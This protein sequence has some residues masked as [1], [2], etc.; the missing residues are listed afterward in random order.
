MCFA[1]RL[2]L[3]AH[4]LNC[5]PGRAWRDG[6]L[7]GRLPVCLATGCPQAARAPGRWASHLTGSV[8]AAGLPA[9]AAC[10]PVCQLGRRAVHVPMHVG[11]LDELALLDQWHKV[12]A[13]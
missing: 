13:S 2:A 3:A 4:L 1:A 6:R 5:L 7:H 9:E 12:H 8:Q 10:L 11:V